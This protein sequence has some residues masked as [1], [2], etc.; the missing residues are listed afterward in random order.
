LALPLTA[1]ELRTK[2]GLTPRRLTLLLRR[3]MP[4]EGKGKK[5]RF[6]PHAVAGWLQA[7]GLA[8][9][10]PGSPVADQ[11]ATTIA[12]TARDLGV[13]PRTVAQWLTDPTFPG[14]AGGPGRR[15]GY[16]PLGQIRDWQAATHAANGRAAV[17]DA[18]MLAARRLKIQIDN[19]RAQIAL[20]KELGSIADGDEVARFLKRQVATAKALLDET[21]DK[22]DSRLPGKIPPA[23]RMRI[24]Q[25][26]EE[27]IAET[28]NS[29]AELAVG[30]QDQAEETEEE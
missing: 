4:S 16:F 18:E 12:E 6:D 13:A 24:R 30:D 1:A 5:R 23:V 15:D 22:V 8:K 17:T 20:E 9:Q 25:A 2:L 7:E 28:L 14:K 3:G 27:V 19:D 29:L 10:D 21:A 11:V 26:I